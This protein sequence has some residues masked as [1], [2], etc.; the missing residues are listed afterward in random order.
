[1][2]VE[3]DSGGYVS[4]CGE[5]YD[6]NHGV[7]DAV[8]TLT[9]TLGGSGS[10]AGSDTGGQAWAEKY[11]A[12]AGPLVQA[13]CQVGEA[14][15][16]MANLL[17][18]S[19]S[20]HEGADYGSRIYGPPMGGSP[21]DDPNPGHWTE[22]LSAA[23]PPS[24]YGGTGGQPGWWH[25]I[26]GHVGGLLWP[27]ADTGRLRS[28]GDAWKTAGQSMSLW[29]SAVDSA[30]GQ[31]GLQ[32][33]PEVPDAVSS[34]HDLRGHLDELSSAYTSIGQACADYAQQVD[35]HHQEIENELKSFIEWTIA[36]EAGG[37]ILG[38]LTFGLG[39]AAAQAAEAAKVAEAAAKVISILNRLIEL[40]RLAA[41]RIGEL[42]AKA[43]RIGDSLKSLLGARKVKALTETGE[44]AAKDLKFLGKGPG[45]TADGA[46]DAKAFATEPNSAFFWSGRTNGV[47]GQNIAGKLASERGGTTLEQLMEK[48][49]IKLP[50]WNADNPEV[51]KVWK[52]A[53]AAYADGA[54]GEVRAVVGD[55]LRPGNVWET[56]ELPSLE[57]N[58]AVTKITTIDPVTG[59]TKVIYP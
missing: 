8:T 26:A 47:G 28:A 53:S 56:A 34:C 55:S 5:F 18:A 29:T 1:M 16:Q 10:M 19:L 22:T 6:A 11:D 17:N 24:A 33:S 21:P 12:A 38:A 52:Q 57:A 3:V 45:F 27:D 51:V 59:A 9:G 54:S 7:V 2:R 15:A 14:M 37:A 40:A 35:D 36:I 4:A 58:P 25:W 49:G 44:L 48:R 50:E 13:G 23:T 43:G 31:I 32:K 20:N 41:V 46:V 30:S 42:V 39:E